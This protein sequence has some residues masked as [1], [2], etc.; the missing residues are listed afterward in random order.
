MT[1]GVFEAGERVMTKDGEG[2]V[3]KS[4]EQKEDQIEVKLNSGEVKTYAATDV[5]DDSDAG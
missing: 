2:V 5:S 3:N 4:Q 1:N